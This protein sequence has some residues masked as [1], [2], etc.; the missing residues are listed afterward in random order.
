MMKE[1]WNISTSSSPRFFR[2]LVTHPGPVTGRWWW[3]GWWCQQRGRWESAEGVSQWSQTPGTC[4]LSWPRPAHTWC[5]IRPK[6]K[7]RAA[8][9]WAASCGRNGLLARQG[10]VSHQ[11]PG[12]GYNGLTSSCNCSKANVYSMKRVDVQIY[13]GQA[14]KDVKKDTAE[15]SGCPQHG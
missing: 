6:Y 11:S 4:E 13:E 7:P 10:A 5:H 9:C 15:K 1:R 8:G 2:A 3:P 12:P 14:L